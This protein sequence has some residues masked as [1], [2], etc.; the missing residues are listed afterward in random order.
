MS[1]GKTNDVYL[2][3]CVMSVLGFL[4]KFFCAVF[5][6]IGVS[7]VSAW[8]HEDGALGKFMVKKQPGQTLER[9]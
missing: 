7:G 8:A 5:L 6:F 4:N 3:N 1:V 2:K 9:V